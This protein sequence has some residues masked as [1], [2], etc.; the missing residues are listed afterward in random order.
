[1]IL[2]KRT[3]IFSVSILILLT[4]LPILGQGRI[5]VEVYTYLS[6][7]SG[8]DL[9]TV[10]NEVA[11]VGFVIA[12][13]IILGDVFEKNTTPWLVASTVTRIIWFAVIVFVLSFGD[14]QHLGLATISSGSGASFNMVEIDLRLFVVLIAGI[15]AMK[16]GYSVLEYRKNK[17]KIPTI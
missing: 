10:L 3:I 6:K 8:I 1:M 11:V 15:I 5:P 14:L 12:S 9:R 13:N 17:A 7:T 16:I 4:A 2:R